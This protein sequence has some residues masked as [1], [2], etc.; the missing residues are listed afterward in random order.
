M[1]KNYDADLVLWDSHPLSLGATPRQVFID[2]IPQLDKPFEAKA[3]DTDTVAPKIASVPKSPITLEEDDDSYRERKEI[4][5]VDEVIF[6]NVAEVLLKD[7]KGLESLG[8]G[9]TSPFSVHLIGSRIECIGTCL[10]PSSGIKHIDLQGGSLLPPLTIIG[11]A[12][13]LTDIISER[14][15]SDSAVY[16]PLVTGELSASQQIWG[17]KIAV[18]AIDGLAFGGKNLRLAERSGVRKAVTAPAGDGFFR[19]VS[20]AFRTGAENGKFSVNR[21]DLVQ[22]G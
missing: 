9:Q 1:R 12:L 2:G 10:S 22:E 5:V 6:D 7:T 18:K 8:K 4:K 13:G 3:L 16:D 11:P 21:S 15:A 19:G 14:T 20:V 17:P